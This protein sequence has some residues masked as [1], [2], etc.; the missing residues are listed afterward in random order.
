MSAT[1]FTPAA[2]ERSLARIYLLEAKSELLKVWRVPAYTLPTLAF[3]MLFYLF[4]GVVMAKKSPQGLQ[5]AT[6]LLATYGTFGVLGASLFGFGVGV[7]ME[8]GQGWMLFK[9]ATPMPPLAHLAGKLAMCLLFS[10]LVVAGL[11]GLGV[12]VGGVTA[13]LSTLLRLGAVT[14][15]GALPFGAMGLAIGYWAGPNSAP[16]LVNLI[17]L[18]MAIGSGLWFPIQ[19]LPTVMQKIAPVF[20]A[21]HL[22]QLGLGILG[23][24]K[25]RVEPL[26]SVVVLAAFTLAALA[27]AWAGYRRDEGRTF[28]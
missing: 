28:G 26:T 19:M 6:Y 13:P 24:G 10:L 23:L 17:Y 16:A 3:P 15:A 1:T 5:I 9:R 11:F 22:A 18:P 25:P 20:P 2:R 21:Y 7:A 14:V 4:F 12:T 8:R 27:L